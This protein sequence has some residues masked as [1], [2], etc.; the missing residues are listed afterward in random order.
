MKA[1]I[2][3]LPIDIDIKKCSNSDFSAIIRQDGVVEY[4]GIYGFIEAV[5]QIE[6]GKAKPAKPFAVTQD[7]EVG[8]KVI[9]THNYGS[10]IADE[11][12]IKHWKG[13]NSYWF[14]ILGEISPNATKFVEDGKEYEITEDFIYTDTTT[15]KKGDTFKIEKYYYKVKCP[16]CGYFK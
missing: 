1:L 8:D 15:M 5:K 3:F 2:K 7:I 4:G 11:S 12:D 14:K 13:G 9:N 10:T 16:C 6:S